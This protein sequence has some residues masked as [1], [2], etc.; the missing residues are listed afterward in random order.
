M[1]KY[2][3]FKT[4][5]GIFKLGL[6]TQISPRIANFVHH[7]VSCAILIIF[8]HR[9]VLIWYGLRRWILSPSLGNTWPI[10]QRCRISRNRK[11]NR[12][13]ARTFKIQY[14]KLRWPDQAP[15][16]VLVRTHYLI[17]LLRSYDTG[18]INKSWIILKLPLIWPNRHLGTSLCKIIG[19]LFST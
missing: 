19:S 17:E 9:H 14:Q 18:S 7:Y 4:V 10:L 6:L 16:W 13:I 8:L 1:N 12:A 2:T 15:I 11:K 3:Q 5:F